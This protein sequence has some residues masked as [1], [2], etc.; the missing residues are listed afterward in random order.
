M[1]KLTTLGPS[2]T[3]FLKINVDHGGD[4]SESGLDAL[5]TAIQDIEFRNNAQRF[6]IL[7]SDAA[8]HDADYDGRSSYSLD[9][10]IETLQREQIRVEVIGLDYL[11]IKQIA[12]ATGGKVERNSWKRL[13]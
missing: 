1:E 8:F 9:V 12:M 2:K 11:P 5:M 4:I 6:F 7:A 13:S 3:G 10:V